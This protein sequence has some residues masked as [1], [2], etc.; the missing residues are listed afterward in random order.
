MPIMAV[1]FA[2]GHLL[3]LRST[4]A[5]FPVCFSNQKFEVY[6]VSSTILRLSTPT[7]L[8]GFVWHGLASPE[9]EI[10]KLY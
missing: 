2:R 5:V 10:S 4:N 9:K 7:G 3:C 1:G 8:A 6:H